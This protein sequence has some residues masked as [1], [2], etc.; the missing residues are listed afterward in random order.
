MRLLGQ[1]SAEIRQREGRIRGALC[2]AVTGDAAEQ[3]VDESVGVPRLHPHGGRDCS[4]LL[5]VHS[6]QAVEIV[7]AK[8]RK[9]VCVRAEAQ[10]GERASNVR[11]D[12]RACT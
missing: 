3:I 8:T 4:Q 6:L 1:L 2:G 11:S 5:L 10:P 9:D 7:V 12:A